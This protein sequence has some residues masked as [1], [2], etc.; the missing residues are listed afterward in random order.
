MIVDWESIPDRECLMLSVDSYSLVD[1][2][3]L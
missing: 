2:K 3:E 1:L